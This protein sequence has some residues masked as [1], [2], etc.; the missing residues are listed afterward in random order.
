[1]PCPWA[2]S[3]EYKKGRARGVNYPGPLFMSGSR[4]EIVRSFAKFETKFAGVSQKRKFREI[5]G[6]LAARSAEKNGGLEFRRKSGRFCKKK[7]DFGQILVGF[8]KVKSRFLGFC[9]NFQIWWCS[10]GIL[11]CRSHS[12]RILRNLNEISN[13][14]CGPTITTTRTTRTT[15]RLANTQQR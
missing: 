14:I 7:S 2:G 1:M 12:G 15:I 4:F 9:D 3:R 13:E 5:C 11:H 6:A 8:C 10:G